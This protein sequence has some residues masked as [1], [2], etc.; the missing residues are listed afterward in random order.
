MF[1]MCVFFE[2]IHS[3][4]LPV[5]HGNVWS[6]FSCRSSPVAAPSRLYDRM[7]MHATKS[8]RFFV[9]STGCWASILFYF[10]DSSACCHI[11]VEGVLDGPLLDKSHLRHTCG[12][13]PLPKRRHQRVDMQMPAV[14]KPNGS[15]A[16]PL[17][18]LPVVSGGCLVAAIAI[19]IAAPYSR[20]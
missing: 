8:H 6:L 5:P 4:V 3:Q 2:N 14:H 15:A 10:S 13:C 20:G 7:P 11:T 19:A 18:K 16:V 17:G 1:L 12:L 9:V